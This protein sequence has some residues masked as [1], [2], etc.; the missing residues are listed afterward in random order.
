MLA[1]GAQAKAR[2]ERVEMAMVFMIVPVGEG[3]SC[4]DVT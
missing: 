4:L 2:R 3:G 1:L